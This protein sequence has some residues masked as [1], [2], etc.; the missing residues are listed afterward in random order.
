M[1]VVTA[2]DKTV[3]IWDVPT[4]RHRSVI[5]ATDDELSFVDVSPD[6]TRVVTV[7]EDDPSTAKVWDRD[8]TDKPAT[9]LRHGGTVRSAEFDPAGTRIVTHELRT[10]FHVWAADTGREACPPVASDDSGYALYRAQF[11]PTGHRLAV[12]R[13]RGF[14]VVELASGK[15]L[16]DVALGGAGTATNRVRFG[17]DGRV[18]AVT[19]WDWVAHGPVQVFD[20]V[21]GDRQKTFGAGIIDCQIAPG[22]R[23]A[24]CL[25]VR[26]SPAD[27]PQLWDL[28]NNRLSMVFARAGE[29]PRAAPRMSPDGSLLLVESDPGVTS[30][31]RLPQG[32]PAT[33]P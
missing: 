4:S 10:A 22:G 13:E 21:T 11:D 18:V 1:T 32:K 17:L 28:S 26:R 19:T 29:G 2:D 25:P 14:A 23:W 8:R 27:L 31:W 6:G 9:A 30:V 15:V 5:R 16:T 7:G 3:W 24:L 33:R 12:P 20:A